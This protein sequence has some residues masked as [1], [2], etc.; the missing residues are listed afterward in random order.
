M[1]TLIETFRATLETLLG[2]HYA[3]NFAKLN[4]VAMPVITL[5]EGV[6]FVRVV[7]GEKNRQSGEVTGRSVYCF[8]RKDNLDILKAAG[9][10][11][12]AKHA[13]GNLRNENMMNGCGPYGVAYL[14]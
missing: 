12:P 3:T 4:A 7:R 5:E 10:K 9:W 11:S 14:R 8:I 1:D 13:R 6:K 2:E